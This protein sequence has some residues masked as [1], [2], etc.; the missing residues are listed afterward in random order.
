MG[1]T[2][3]AA[4]LRSICFAVLELPI[5]VIA[6]HVLFDVW[7]LAINIMF[8]EFNYVVT[9]ISSLFFLLLHCIPFC[10]YITVYLSKLLDT[11]EG[12]LGCFQLGAITNNTMNILVHVFW[13]LEVSH[14]LGICLGVELPVLGAGTCLTLASANSATELSKMAVSMNA[15]TSNV[16]ELESLHILASPWWCPLLCFCSTFEKFLST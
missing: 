16:R 5:N 1:D 10:D 2:R 15:P 3:G 11:I 14:L 13:W 12:P 4:P 7:L 9:C 6:H 8:F